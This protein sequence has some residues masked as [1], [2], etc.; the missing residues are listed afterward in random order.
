MK[1]MELLSKAEHIIGDLEDTALADLAWDTFL[2]REELRNL[3]VILN[4]QT[5]AD[6]QSVLAELCPEAWDGEQQYLRERGA[7]FRCSTEYLSES[8]RSSPATWQGES[9]SD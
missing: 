3:P 7:D 5:I 9:E 1:E 8:G 6:Y 4:D 2:N